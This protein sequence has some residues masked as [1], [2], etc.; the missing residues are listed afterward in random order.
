MGDLVSLIQNVGFP[1]AVTVYLLYERSGIQKEITQNLHQ[2]ALN[3]K[4]LC[5]MLKHDE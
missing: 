4:E 2:I 3:L 1:I 5:I